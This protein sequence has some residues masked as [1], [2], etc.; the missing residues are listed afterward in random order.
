LH[1]GRYAVNQGIAILATTTGSV[2]IG[3]DFGTS[4][5]AVAAVLDGKLTPVMLEPGKTVLPS[6]FFALD[7]EMPR[8]QIDEEVLRNRVTASRAEQDSAARERKEAAR[9]PTGSGN[10]ARPLRKLSDEEL[11]WRER[12]LMARE[13]EAAQEA[14]L[15][16]R[17]FTER[18][19]TARQIYMGTPAINARI[20]N[21][22]GGTFFKSPKRFLGSRIREDQRAAF[23][24]VICR[25]LTYIRNK[26][27][28]RVHAPVTRAVLGRPVTYSRDLDGQ[29]DEEAISVMSSAARAAGFAEIEFLME[30]VAAALDYERTLTEET[31]V[32]VID[33]G[34]GTTDCSVV[35]LGPRRA[36]LRDRSGDVLSSTGTRHGG[37]DIDERVA[38]RSV[39]PLL[40]N[41]GSYA[42]G[43]RLPDAI[44]F[45]AVSIHSIPDQE[46]FYSST[47][48]IE[49]LIAVAAEPQKVRRLLK[50]LHDRL[51][52][53]IVRDAELTKI[54]LSK[55]HEADMDLG[56]IEDELTA[57]V[58]QPELADAA[59]P[60]VAAMLRVAHEAI[61]QAQVQPKVVYV[62]G[63]TALSPT[64]RDA[65]QARIGASVRIEV[66][67]MF[68]SV[69][70]GLGLHA[71]RTFRD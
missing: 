64:V 44:Y 69:A 15:R 66:G 47:R 46:S 35:R 49:R 51:T 56:Y 57:S 55:A 61:A 21:P 14:W 20:G 1:S 60:V 18:L 41:G 53:R 68:G 19:A 27:E 62:T 33:A 58:S 34:G 63:G 22:I 7:P 16:G 5:C 38:V 8:I 9:G 50:V 54:A 25:M 31:P 32:L 26:C 4:N 11:Y 71:S 37:V 45:E 30:P 40:G 67:D 13:A 23:E 6:V 65:I 10:F 70:S 42:Y 12:S 28:A 52:F 59:E 36:R 24:Q 39:T 43:G 2:P 3:L 48:A 29:H 17:S